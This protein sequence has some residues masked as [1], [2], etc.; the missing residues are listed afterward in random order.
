MQSLLNTHLCDEVWVLV[1]DG[2][3]C[4]QITAAPRIMTYN[5]LQDERRTK[6]FEPTGH[7]VSQKVQVVSQM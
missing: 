5:F 2:N 6:C 4:P 3:W 7:S 1:P